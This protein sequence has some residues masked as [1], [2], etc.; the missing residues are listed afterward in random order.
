MVRRMRDDHAKM[1][2]DLQTKY[3]KIIEGIQEQ[4]QGDTNVSLD[5]FTWSY[6]FQQMHIYRYRLQVTVHT[7]AHQK[8]ACP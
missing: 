2:E 8:V 6:R 3:T 7:A 5:G 4:L 1:V